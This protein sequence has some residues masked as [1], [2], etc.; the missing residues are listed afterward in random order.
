MSLPEESNLNDDFLIRE[1]ILSHD[2][3]D[4]FQLDDCQMLLSLVEATFCCTTTENV[5]DPRNIVVTGS[6]DEPISRTIYKI[7]NEIQ[8]GC[9]ED[10]NLHKKT[11]A[12]LELLGHYRWDAKVVLALASFAHCFASF[13]LILQLQPDNALAVS[14]A[15]VKQLPR[16]I[17]KPKFKALSLLVNTMLKLSKIIV[18]FEGVSLHHELVD[19][20]AM[21]VAMKKIYL[22]TYWFFR[23]ILVCSSQ[24][25]DLR[26]CLSLEQVSS[27]RTV[28]AAW[29]L[30]SLGKKLDDLCRNLVQD[31]ENCTHQIDT[32]L[33]EKLLRLFTE[34]QDDNQKALHSLFASQNEFPFS[35]AFS[36]DKIGILEL[37]SKTILLLISTPALLPL[38]KAFSLVQQTQTKENC[39]VIWLPIASTN[40]WSLVDRTSFEFF[41]KRLPWFSVRKP[42]QLNSAAVNYIRQ[43]WSFRQ[44]PIMVALDDEGLVANA[45]AMDMMWVWGS[46]AFPFSTSTETQL[47][48][49]ANWNIELMINGIISPALMSQYGKEGRNLCIYG[50]D[51]IDWIKE[52]N[53]TIKKMKTIAGVQLEVVYV[54]I[55][56]LDENVKNILNT[57][58]QENTTISLTFNNIHLFWI[59][60]EAIKRSISRHLDTPNGDEIAGRVS[61]LLEMKG[62]GWAVIGGGSSNGAIKFDQEKLRECMGRFSIN[63]NVAEMGLVAAINEACASGGKCMH[64]EEIPY[65]EGL[66]E[67]M[68]ICG[69]CRRPIKKFV[70]YK[71]D[72]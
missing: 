32:R 25:P 19:N 4:S 34:K 6:S 23:G 31:V 26:S 72:K 17:L 12:L 29:G 48:E 2:P 30:H 57:I 43:E 66:I 59:R 52:F 3:D 7:S 9:E 65:E 45:D 22:A 15:I 28:I 42:W 60:L 36:R 41:S 11:L 61:E 14:L 21:D 1:I 51:N 27:D 44:D 49:Q 33:Y 47:W 54:G 67:K 5:F 70:L 18:Q 63:K 24:F 20:R 10:A 39:V 53:Q 58:D 55:K 62:G 8:Y 69:S 40:E 37:K 46:K 56:N 35:N 13:W 38:D 71:C 64:D 50:S 16:A 68:M